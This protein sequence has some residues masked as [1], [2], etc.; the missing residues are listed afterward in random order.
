M[1]V[2]LVTLEVKGLRG[3]VAKDWVGEQGWE[4]RESV[5]GVTGVAR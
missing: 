2:G 1:C 4:S 5:L 3:V